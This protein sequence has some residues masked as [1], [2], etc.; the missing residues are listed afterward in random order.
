VVLSE[1][2]KMSLPEYKLL[3]DTVLSDPNWDYGTLHSHAEISQV[4]GV[5][6]KTP[7]YYSMITYANRR[8]RKQGKILKSIRPQGYQVAEPRDY[9]KLA[10]KKVMEGSRKIEVGCEIAEFAPTKRMSR[11]EL[12]AHRAVTDKLR[13][14]EAFLGAAKKEVSVAA[15]GKN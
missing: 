13:S 15:E 12:M 1:K 3:V 11:H 7:R 14:Y 2:N 4:L 9:A 5:K 6:P 8:L 10:A